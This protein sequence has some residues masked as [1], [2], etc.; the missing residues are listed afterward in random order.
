[1]NVWV[2]LYPPEP[3]VDT[4]VSMQISPSELN[5][6]VLRCASVYAWQAWRYDCY[7]GL[8]MRRWCVEENAAQWPF[9]RNLSKS[10]DLV[11][12]SVWTQTDTGRQT[13]AD[14]D[15]GTASM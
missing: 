5:G 4:G 15:T 14:T 8:A 12:W 10:M 1:M 11:A 9:G 6:S 2:T 7:E 3:E 13:E